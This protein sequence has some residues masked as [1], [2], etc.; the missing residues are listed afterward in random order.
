VRESLRIL[1]VDG[2]TLRAKIVRK[3]VRN[4]N[5]T[6][7]GN[8]LRVSAPPSVHQADLEATVR[9]LARTLVRRV[10]AEELNSDDQA[11]A[12]ARKVAERFPRPPRVR[13]VRFVTTQR[14]RWGSYSPST[15]VVRLNAALRV[16]PTWVL[17]AVVAHELAHSIYADHSPG[18]WAL[19][20]RVCP[21]TDRANAFLEGV[22]WITDRWDRLP[23]VERSL[24][25]GG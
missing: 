4:V 11:L 8:E 6:L 21:K 22:S 19:L 18:F 25:A 2:V 10:R 24:L 17:E 12:I 15:G 16:L 5:V 3:P 9:R 7:V 13:A 14:R 1:T 23:P 20:R